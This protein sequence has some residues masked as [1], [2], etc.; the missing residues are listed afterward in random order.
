MITLIRIS[1]AAAELGI[2]V[3]TA[4][5]WFYRGILEGETKPRRD[6]KLSLRVTIASVEKKAKELEAERSKRK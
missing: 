6:G 5:D 4:R 3:S 2:S 1:D